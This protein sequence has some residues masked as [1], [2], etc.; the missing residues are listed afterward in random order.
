MRFDEQHNSHNVT[1]AIIYCRVSSKAQV[2]RG[3]GLQSQQTRCR[4]YARY[5]VMMSK[6]SSQ[7]T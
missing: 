4:E 5:K 7:T 2:K 6:R 1:D 3:D